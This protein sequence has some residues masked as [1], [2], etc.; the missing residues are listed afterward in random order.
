MFYVQSISL[1]MNFGG[2]GGGRTWSTVHFLF[3]IKKHGKSTRA[4]PILKSN[5]TSFWFN[6]LFPWMNNK[7]I[8]KR[9]PQNFKERGAK[10][11]CNWVKM[12]RVAPC[13]IPTLYGQSP[14]LWGRRG[15]WARIVLI[16]FIL[17]FPTLTFLYFK[18][19]LLQEFSS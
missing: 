12:S 10:R 2:D 16:F 18:W 7:K 9:G 6:N 19:R 4:W 15:L 8:K 3:I 11:W 14:Y 17:H 1:Y 5:S 13:D